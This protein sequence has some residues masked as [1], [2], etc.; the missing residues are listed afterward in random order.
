M[1]F[2]GSTHWRNYIVNILKIYYVCKND[3]VDLIQNI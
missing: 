3:S 1:Y 2:D